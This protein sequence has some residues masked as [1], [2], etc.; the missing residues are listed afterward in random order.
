MLLRDITERVVA[1]LGIPRQFD[2]AAGLTSQSD[3]TAS[4]VYVGVS[5]ADLSG[6][7]SLVS[8][9]VYIGVWSAALSGDGSLSAD[10]TLVHDTAANLASVSNLTATAILVGLASSIEVGSSD[11]TATATRVVPLDASLSASSELV[12]LGGLIIS[13]ESVLAAEA[14]LEASGTYV[15]IADASPMSAELVLSPPTPL[16]IYRL[17]P[18]TYEQVYT[19]FLPY[20]RYGI[21]TGKTV[22]ISD[23]TVIVTDYPNDLDLEAADAYYLGGH[24]YQLDEAQY[25][26]LVA[27]GGG[28]LVEVG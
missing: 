23:N 9:A 24:W 2:G 28:Y 21:D 25:Q 3:L 11:L 20:S 19:D 12:A 18:G 14:A 1:L 13:A 4:G 17:K 8:A 22:I 7:S 10:G 6:D 16:P 5:A 26:Q 27:A 15:Q